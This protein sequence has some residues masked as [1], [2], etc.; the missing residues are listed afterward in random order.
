MNKSLSI[1]CLLLASLTLLTGPNPPETEDTQSD[2]EKWVESDPLEVGSRRW[3]AANH[4]RDEWIVTLAMGHPQ[5]RLKNHKD[6]IPVPLPFKI[7]AGPAKEG[8]HGRRQIVKVSDGWIVGFNAGEWGGGLW[9]FSPDGKQRYK[10][11]KAR[12]QGFVETK[13]GLL[14]MEGLAHISTFEGTIMTI[15]KNQNNKWESKILIDIK[16]KPNV[17]VHFE[18]DTLLLATTNRL[19]KVVPDTKEI[20]VIADNMFWIGLYPNSMVITRG[21]VI[22]VGMRH[23]VAKIERE[24]GKARIHWLLPK[25]EPDEK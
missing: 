10:I 7:E 8:L 19:L 5:A 12:V 21:G 13:Q 17:W 24:V 23:G 15:K 4:D 16:D 6:D 2:L 18:D 22:Y 14:V 3:S 25:K 1:V 11:A 20:E 9:W